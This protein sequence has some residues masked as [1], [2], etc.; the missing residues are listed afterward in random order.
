MDPNINVPKVVTALQKDPKTLSPTDAQ[1][2]GSLA[3]TLEPVLQNKA[4]LGNTKSAVQRLI[5]QQ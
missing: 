4:A 1:A 2:L 5:K 3:N